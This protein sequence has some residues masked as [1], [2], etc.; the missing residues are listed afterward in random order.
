MP[1]EEIRRIDGFGEKHVLNDNGGFSSFHHFEQEDEGSNRT[2]LIGGALVVALLLGAVGIY[3]YTGSGSHPAGVTAKVPASSVASNLPAAAPIQTTPTPAPKMP[4][5]A[6]QPSRHT[7]PAPA[8]AGDTASAA[9][10]VTSGKPVKSARAHVAL[11]KDEAVQNTAEAEPT[12]QMNRDS[13]AADRATK[14]GSVAVTIAGCPGGRDECGRPRCLRRRHLRSHRWPAM[15]S[16]RR[17]R[18]RVVLRRMFPR[19]RP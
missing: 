9:P 13:S 18:K 11:P 19:P 3:A 17:R 14:N 15:V 5:S 2:K 4:L 16:L 10:D 8:P 12:A 6:R 1:P 7:M